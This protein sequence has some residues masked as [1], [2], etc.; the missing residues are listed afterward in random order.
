M[1]K[2]D[3]SCFFRAISHQLYGHEEEHI[4][5]RTQLLRFVNF[6]EDVFSKYLIPS[7]NERTIQAHI[8]KV[9]NPSAWATHIEVFAAATYY[10]IPV[11]Y[12]RYKPHLHWEVIRPI[13]GIFRYPEM[14]NSSE[15][16][17]Q[18]SHL[19]LVYKDMYHYDSVMS[20]SG[21]IATTFPK[22]PEQVITHKDTL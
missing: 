1:V 20:I 17:I 21:G 9:L 7:V 2:P 11:F 14:I 18:P 15:I 4:H 22:I 8:D 19:E 10:Q 6:N 5:I 16:S 12:L 3:G 13:K